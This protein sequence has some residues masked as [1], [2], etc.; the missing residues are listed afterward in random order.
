[1]Q[2]VIQ[3]LSICCP[4]KKC[5]NHCETC[6]ARQHDNPYVDKFNGSRCQTFEYWNDVIKRM[7]YAQDKGC[8]TVMLTGSVEP[9]QN[10]RWLEGLYLAM[11]SLPKPFLNIEMQ[12]TGA[13]IDKDYLLFLKSM[14]VTTLAISTFNIFD[15][16][17][18]R[19]IEHCAD[20]TLKLYD[21]CETAKG[22][23]FNIRI[24][25]NIT[26]YAFTESFRP[27]WFMGPDTSIRNEIQRIFARCSELFADQVT[28]RKMWSVDG[29]PEGEWIKKNCGSHCEGFLNGINDY[30]LRNGKLLNVLP[31]GAARFDCSGLSIVV[32]TDSMAKDETNMATKYYIIR[33]N[34]KMYS[35]WDS[36]ASLVF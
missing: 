31:Y 6:T 23:G 35:S 9:Q 19:S 30:V 2:E 7:Q 34:G 32:D 8:T 22:L 27:Q 15:D 10:R 16:E 13:F 11:K 28:F 29:T 25:V 14:G 33:E 24:C 17:V 36:K 4:A 20:E 12:T 26:D 1:M 5:I 3:S 21:L 18:N